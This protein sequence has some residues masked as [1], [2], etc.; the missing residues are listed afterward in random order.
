MFFYIFARLQENLWDNFQVIERAQVYDLD[1]YLKCLKN[2][3]SK[4]RKFRIMVLVFCTSYHGDKNLHKVSRKYR[5][6]F[7]SYR[8]D[9][10][11]TEITIFNVQSTIIPKVG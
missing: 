9:T 4:S 8:V 5:K 7:S 11:I 10:I 2:S 1:H 6:Q 3:N